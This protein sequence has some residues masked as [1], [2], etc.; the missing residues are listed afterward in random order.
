MKNGLLVNRSIA[1]IFT[2]ATLAACQRA[3]NK[4]QYQFCAN[5]KQEKGAVKE[6]LIELAMRNKMQ[7]LDRS[8]E[9]EQESR[10]LDKENSRIGQSYPLIM[11]S[12]WKPSGFTL[13]VTNAGLPADQLVLGITSDGQDVSQKFATDALNEFSRRWRL[14]TVPPGRGARPLTCGE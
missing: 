11:M 5:V 10:L 14:V 4:V 8:A 1:V 6:T 2:L 3:D 9:A 12:I 13:T 7:F